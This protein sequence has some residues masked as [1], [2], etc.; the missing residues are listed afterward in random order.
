[1]EKGTDRQTTDLK[2]HGDGGASTLLLLIGGQQL[3]LS[4]DLR[5]LHPSHALNPARTHTHT[6]THTL[7]LNTG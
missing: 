5:L 2:L 6:H 4:T 7:T 1:M 3:N